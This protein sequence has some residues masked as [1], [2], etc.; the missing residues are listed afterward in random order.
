MIK[1]ISFIGSGNVATQFALSFHS[2]GI[3]II[4]IFSRNKI[5]G[6]QLAR[7]VN[8]NYTNEIKNIKECDL[9]MICVNDDSIKK[10]ANILPNVLMIH[11]S[12]CTS[13]D[14]FV[15][16]NNFG[17]IYPVQ[18]LT[19]DIKVNFKKIPICIEANNKITEKKL[20]K[21]LSKVSGCINIM[22][23]KNRKILH[24]AAVISC[25]FSN[26]CY[27]IAQ[28]ILE[29]QN[30]DFNLLNHLI[31]HTADK[32]TKSKAY[33]NLTGPARRGDLMTIQNHIDLIN[34]KKYKKIYKLLSDS[35]LNEY[36]KEL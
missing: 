15:N 7:K 20:N 10:I 17:V 27:L 5:T 31:K 21:L 11:T 9:I 30:I 12:G 33:E 29:E 32:N 25:N 14:V 23:S 13:L 35:I 34:D 22:N 26:Y 36:K 8:A 6:K 4:N 1:S 18:T 3:K 16:K 2:V 28:N 19:K 24:L